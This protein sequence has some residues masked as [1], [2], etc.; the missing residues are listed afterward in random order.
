MANKTQPKSPKHEG[1]DPL[2]KG[3]TL[4]PTVNTKEE[5]AKARKNPVNVDGLYNGSKNGGRKD[6]VVE[7]ADEENSTTETPTEETAAEQKATTDSKS[8]TSSKN[9]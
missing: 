9:K 4:Y 3:Q 1:V 5:S 7:T 8:K 2:T 6:G